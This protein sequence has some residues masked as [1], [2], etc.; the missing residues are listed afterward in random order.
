MSSEQ[1]L[2]CLGDVDE[3]YILDVVPEMVIT[4]HRRSGWK[5]VLVCAAVISLLAVTAFAASGLGTRLVEVFS[6]ENESG[7]RMAAEVEK[8]PVDAFTGEVREASDV[9]QQQ[10]AA[11]SPHESWSPTD[12]HREF[13]SSEEARD[14]LGFDKLKSLNW[15]LEEK[16][17]SLHVYGDV[18]GQLNMITLETDYQVDDIRIQTF[19]YIYTE[20]YEADVVTGTAAAE[21]L[22]F[23]ESYYS[24]QNGKQCH[25][26]TSS[27]MESGW[28]GIEGYLVDDGVLYWVNV[29]YLEK[30]AV[31][32]KALLHLWAD[33]F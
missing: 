29:A 33:Q 10:Y 23:E 21:R 2:Q 16:F 9:I 7:F 1:L 32:A 20:Y 5:R 13:A 17:T 14:Y 18:G 25:I 15:V 24:T 8:F 26:I 3:G 12:F 19:S 4:R 22:E 31:Q 30:D 11:Y 6:N 27:A 28:L